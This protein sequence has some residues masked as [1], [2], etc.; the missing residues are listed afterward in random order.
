MVIVYR[1]FLF[2]FC[3]CNSLKTS[4]YSVLFVRNNDR[5]DKWGVC[6]A[7]NI[8]QGFFLVVIQEIVVYKAGNFFFC[9][10]MHERSIRH[11]AIA[12]L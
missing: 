2:F 5:Y 1:E 3:Q 9:L 7:Y 8:V 4:T 6:L 12:Y 11:H 10:Y